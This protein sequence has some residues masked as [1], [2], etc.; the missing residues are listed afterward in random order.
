MAW[1]ALDKIT[2]SATTYIATSGSM[3]SLLTSMVNYILSPN[4]MHGEVTER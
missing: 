3:R 4:V 1:V 2:K